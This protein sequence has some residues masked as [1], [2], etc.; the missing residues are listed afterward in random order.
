VT[1][2]AACS[3][4]SLGSK[5]AWGIPL[6]LVTI[7]YVAV[8]V[9]PAARAKGERRYVAAC[10]AAAAAIALA[11]ILAPGGVDAFAG[12]VIGGLAIAALLGAIAFAVRRERML[13]Y[14][15]GSILSAGAVPAAI[16]VVFFGA[17]V[18]TDA[19]LA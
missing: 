3:P 6:I 12:R 1:L 13:T 16:V 4:V 18:F 8:L 17:L 9:V 11:L 5:L 19:C 14:V 2:V 15:L 7:A 10:W